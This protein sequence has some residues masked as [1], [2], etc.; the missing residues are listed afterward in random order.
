MKVVTEGQD[1]W[2]PWWVG[3]LMTCSECGRVVELEDGD[4]RRADWMPTQED[5]VV[6]ACVRCGHKVS[7]DRKNVQNTKA[8][9]LR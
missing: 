6:I 7:I 9:G 2:S 8:E 4:E 1:S 5:R 3:Q